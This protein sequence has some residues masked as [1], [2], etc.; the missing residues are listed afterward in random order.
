MKQIV[1]IISVFLLVQFSSCTKTEQVEVLVD[2]QMVV[3]GL[4]EPNPDLIIFNTELSGINEVPAVS[5][6][7]KGRATG[8]INKTSKL[9]N[10]VIEHSGMTPT[11]WHIH[12]GASTAT[13]A[14]MV[15]L[16]TD[17]FP[18]PFVYKNATPFTDAIFADIQSGNAYVNI[19]SM[20]NSGG[21]IRGQLVKADPVSASFVGLFDISAKT[22]ELNLT[23]AGNGFTPTKMFIVNNANNT[24][25]LDLGSTFASPARFVT[26]ALTEAQIADLKAGKWNF[27]I[28]STRVPDGELRTKLVVK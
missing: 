1:Y 11:A 19:H 5:T 8:N 12:R 23:Y 17:A 9:M 25:V 10:L 24:E 28:N 7:A 13:G 6:P 3:S 18:S 21:E 14:V 20:R 16:S 26:P 2:K 4:L 22:L 15:T 27:Q